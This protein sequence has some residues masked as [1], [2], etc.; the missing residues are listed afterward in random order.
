MDFLIISNFICFVSIH[1]YVYLFVLYYTAKIIH[2]LYDTAVAPILMMSQVSYTRGNM[3][4][5][6]NM[7]SSMIL[8]NIFLLKEWL[9]CGSPYH[10][11]LMKHHQLIVLKCD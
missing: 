6:Q 11:W 5:L 7:Y 8:E 10:P 4:K 3:Y 2:G 1:V 9:T